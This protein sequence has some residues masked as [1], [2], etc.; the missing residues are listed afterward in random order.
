MILIE[1]ENTDVDQREITSEKGN[2]SVREQKAFLQVPGSKYP[3][4]FTM[5]LGKDQLPFETGEYEFEVNSLFI[6]RY[7]Q[8]AVKRE[9][10]LQK[11]KGEV[12]AA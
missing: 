11:L 5:Q 3:V 12:A 6:N 10:A 2:F 4:G 8:L 7:G 1:I 9:L